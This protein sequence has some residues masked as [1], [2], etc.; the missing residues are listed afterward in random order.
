MALSSDRLKPFHPPL[1]ARRVQEILF[2]NSS[3]YWSYV[4]TD[5]HSLENNFIP[6]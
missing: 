5:P 6:K 4:V 1:A 3:L 2:G